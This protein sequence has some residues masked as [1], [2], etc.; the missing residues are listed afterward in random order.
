MISLDDIKRDL[1]VTHDDD[2]ALL[3]TL[4]DASEREAVN[5]MD[6]AA[7]PVVGGGE[8]SSES[9]PVVEPDVKVAVFLLVRSKYDAATAAEIEGLRKAAETLLTPYRVSWG[10]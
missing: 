7:L 2:D 1:R 6:L 4:L 8:A 5:Y 10:V 9:E 3:Q